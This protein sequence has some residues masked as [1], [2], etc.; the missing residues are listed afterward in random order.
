MGEQL[1]ALWEDL[2]GEDE[3]EFWSRYIYAQESELDKRNKKQEI[4]QWPRGLVTGVGL[5]GCR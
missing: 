1:S 4:I 2:S 5:V 3:E